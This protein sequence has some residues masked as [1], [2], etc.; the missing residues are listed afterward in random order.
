MNKYNRLKQELEESGR[1]SMKAFGNPML[2]IIKSGSTLTFEKRESYEIGDIV[3]C[4]VKGRFIDA[5]KITKEDPN[6]G[7]MIANNHG[8][9]NGWTKTIFGKVVQGEFNGEIRQ[10]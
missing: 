4:K 5:H 8:F 6:K 7:F 3:F 9:E 1:G 10:L 2:P